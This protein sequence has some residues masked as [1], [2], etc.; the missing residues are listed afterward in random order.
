MMYGSSQPLFS[1]LCVA[2]LI[3]T[4]LVHSIVGE[5]R[6][7]TPLLAERQ[8]VLQHAQARFLIRM[9]WHFMSVLFCIIAVAIAAGFNAPEASAKALL[10]A[11]G[12]G[13]GGAGLFDAIAT[14][15]KHIG[16]PLLVLIGVFALLAAGGPV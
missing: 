14:R 11:T 7:I 3:A 6:L 4:S 8:G 16:W 12:V 10:Q 1:S 5:R 2:L 13:I 9:V 15:G